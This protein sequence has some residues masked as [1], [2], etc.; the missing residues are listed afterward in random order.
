MAEIRPKVARQGSFARLKQQIQVSTGRVAAGRQAS[1]ERYK[2]VRKIGRRHELRRERRQ[3]ATNGVVEFSDRNPDEEDTVM[4]AQVRIHEIASHNWL[5]EQT[6]TC[7]GVSGRRLLGRIVSLG[8]S[9]PFSVACLGS[10]RHR[11]AHLQR[12]STMSFWGVATTQP[13]ATCCTCWGLHTY[14]TALPR[15]QITLRENSFT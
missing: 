11:Q 13:I 7:S 10:V 15:C 9:L 14:A 2:S 12:F 8:G 5:A 1:L 3:R 6:R 4:E